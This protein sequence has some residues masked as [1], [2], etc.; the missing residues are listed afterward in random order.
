MPFTLNKASRQELLMS[1]SGYF[2]RFNLLA[3]EA[4][5]LKGDH[6]RGATEMDKEEFERI[7][8]RLL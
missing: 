8:K 1:I 7:A 4:R 6:R 3:G 2:T 5:D